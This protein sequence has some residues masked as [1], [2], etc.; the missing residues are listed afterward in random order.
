MQYCVG[1]FRLRVDDKSRR[2]GKG[3]FHGLALVLPL[4]AKSNDDGASRLCM[5]GNTCERQANQDDDST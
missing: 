5:Y 2:W 4:D 3:H 1:L